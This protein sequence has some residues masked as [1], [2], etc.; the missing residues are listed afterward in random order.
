MFRISTLVFGASDA[1]AP[2]SWYSWPQARIARTRADYCPSSLV[3]CGTLTD[4]RRKALRNGFSRQDHVPSVIVCNEL[5]CLSLTFVSSP[6]RTLAAKEIAGVVE[7]AI[8]D[9]VIAAKA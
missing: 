8:P 9:R 3:V 7:A 5:I 4:G 2:C 1:V 6:E